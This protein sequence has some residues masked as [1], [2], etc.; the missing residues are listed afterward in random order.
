MKIDTLGTISHEA[1]PICTPR[2]L[3][4]HLRRLVLVQVEVPPRAISQY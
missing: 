1:P 4:G 2:R 3:T